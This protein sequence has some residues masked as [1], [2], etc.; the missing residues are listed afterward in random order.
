MT[1][2]AFISHSNSEDKIIPLT[3]MRSYMVIKNYIIVQNIWSD[4]WL[5]RLMQLLVQAIYLAKAFIM[6][7]WTSQDSN[8]EMNSYYFI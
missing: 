6:N 5:L 4:K 3:L 1:A 2:V 7:T 8:V